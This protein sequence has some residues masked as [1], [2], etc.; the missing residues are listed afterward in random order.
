VRRERM[1]ECVVCAD[2]HEKTEMLVLPCEHAYCAS[3]DCLH[4]PFRRALREKQPFRCCDRVDIDLAAEHFDAAFVADYKLMLLERDTPNPLYC[5]VPACSRFIVP[6][7]IKGGVGTCPACSVR[8]C[9]FC[10]LA[11]HGGVCREDAEGQRVRA[12]ARA[13]G[14]KVCP[15]CQAVVE[16]N[17]GCLH[18]TCRCGTEFCYSCNALYS[19][20]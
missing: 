13:A 4:A 15:N 6:A 5:S 3:E 9:A 12:L 7:S 16:R 8:T 10:R 14:W 19:Q 1:A 17:A 11:E 20:C 2:E 18:M